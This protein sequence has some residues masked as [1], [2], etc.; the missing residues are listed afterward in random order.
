[1]VEISVGGVHQFEGSKTDVVKGFIIDT[2]GFVGVLDELMNRQG[3]VVGLD[4]GVG[5]L[6]KVIFSL[7]MKTKMIR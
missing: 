5:H 3:G 7:Q 1:M 6:A 2:E 4:N